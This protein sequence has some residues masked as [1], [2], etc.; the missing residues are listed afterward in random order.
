[1][2]EVHTLFDLALDHEPLDKTYVHIRDSEYCAEHR[3]YWMLHGRPSE[4]MQTRSRILLRRAGIPVL[5]QSLV[6]APSRRMPPTGPRRRLRR[7]T[8]LRG[9]HCLTECADGFE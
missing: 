8:V 5:D 1:M 2:R 3:T 6:G 4:I 9:R 7:A